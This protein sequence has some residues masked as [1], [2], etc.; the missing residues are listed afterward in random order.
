VEKFWQLTLI[1]PLE[2]NGEKQT[3]V[4]FSVMYTVRDTETMQYGATVRR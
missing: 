2:K 1:A 4:T 3:T